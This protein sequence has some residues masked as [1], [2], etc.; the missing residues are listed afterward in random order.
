MNKKSQF[1]NVIVVSGII[2]MMLVGCSNPAATN[3]VENSGQSGL[4]Q[5]NPQSEDQTYIAIGDDVNLPASDVQQGLF[6]NMIDD[7]TA[8][9]EASN[10]ELVKVLIPQNMLST[11]NFETK[12]WGG[13]FNFV[14]GTVVRYF[15]PKN[16]VKRQVR[17]N[18][19]GIPS[20]CAP[21]PGDT[22]D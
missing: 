15:T 12:F 18:F 3:F 21:G 14:R 11:N 4:L 17:K 8:L 9:V 1:F 20:A 16:V 6:V 2:S 19:F 5:S 22:C 7:Q 13:V 10:G